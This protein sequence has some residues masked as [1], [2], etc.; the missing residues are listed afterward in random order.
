MAGAGGRVIIA[1]RSE[2]SS[3]RPRED[4]GRLAL[5]VAATGGSAR[6]RDYGL[7]AAIAAVRIAAAPFICAYGSVGFGRAIIFRA[8]VASGESPTITEGRNRPSRQRRC[9]GRSSLEE[10]REGQATLRENQG[11]ETRSQTWSVLV[12]EVISGHLAI[13]LLPFRRA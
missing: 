5:G 8:Y 9:P 12:S 10:S 3:K 7:R 1:G 13:P 6:L 2:I 11:I 4:Y